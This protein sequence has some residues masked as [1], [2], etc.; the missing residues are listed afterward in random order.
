MHNF[1]FSELK[2]LLNEINSKYDDI[3]CLCVQLFKVLI[4]RK[5]YSHDNEYLKLYI[6][7]KIEKISQTLNL[8]LSKYYEMD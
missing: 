8:I 2:K 5:F 4:V 1:Y 3:K 7:K 6:N